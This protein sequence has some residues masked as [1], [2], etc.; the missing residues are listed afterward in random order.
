MNAE[1]RQ[2]E[3]K[4]NILQL[5]ILSIDTK[6]LAKVTKQVH[7]TAG[8]KSISSDTDS[9]HQMFSLPYNW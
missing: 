9:F 7:A 1:D 3:K 6:D 4:K 2:R 8:T 5:D